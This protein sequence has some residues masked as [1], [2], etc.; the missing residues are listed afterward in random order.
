MGDGN[1]VDGEFNHSVLDG[2]DVLGDARVRCCLGGGTVDDEELD[3]VDHEQSHGASHVTLFF[4]TCSK[5]K[6]TLRHPLPFG[7]LRA[8]LLI[9][10]GTCGSSP[11]L[12]LP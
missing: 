6:Q 3:G 11:G 10:D 4:N 1:D 2:D 5:Q 8:V 12:R 9:V 7:T